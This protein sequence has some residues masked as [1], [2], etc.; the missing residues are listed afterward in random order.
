MLSQGELVAVYSGRTNASMA[1]VDSS[2]VF[3]SSDGGQSWNDRTDS[4]MRQFTQSL[5]V[6][7]NDPSDSTWFACVRDV[8][9]N[10]AAAGLYRTTDRG[11]TWTKLFDQPLMSCTFHPSR[12]N[13]MYLCSEFDG[14]WH[15]TGAGDASPVFTSLTA[16]PFRRP[17]RV[18]FN[19]YDASQVW[20]TSEGNGMR[21]G[22]APLTT[23]VGDPAPEG[24]ELR[25]ASAN[26]IRT[27]AVLEYAL[28]RA[29][30]VSLTVSDVMGRTVAVLEHGIRA[31]GTHRV[32]WNL[33]RAGSGLYF[34]RLDGAN[35][36]STRKLVVNR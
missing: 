6:D 15:V 3:F 20:V 8:P 24:G 17:T 23:A 10:P 32:T 13:E 16:Y 14:L 21:M 30:K 28:P 1:F 36:R 26:P 34:A 7:R 18:F 11:A 27:R 29:A 33:D 5:T 4:R 35:L 25:L 31:A 12:P 2:G 19:P 9:T 22:I